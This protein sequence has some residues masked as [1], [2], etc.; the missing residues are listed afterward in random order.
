MAESIGESAHEEASPPASPLG[1]DGV[2]NEHGYVYTCDPELN[3]DEKGERLVSVD[4]VLVLCSHCRGEH[5]DRLLDVDEDAEDADDEN[6]E[7]D[8]YDENDENDEVREASLVSK[9]ISWVF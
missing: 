8:E 1:A 5:G 4:P 9:T 2:E 7:N 6:D 3:W